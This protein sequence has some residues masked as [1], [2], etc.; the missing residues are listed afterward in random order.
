MTATH[1]NLSQGCLALTLGALVVLKS[2]EAS[3][4]STTGNHLMAQAGLVVELRL[5]VVAVVC[6]VLVCKKVWQTDEE[7]LTHLLVRIL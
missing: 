4:G 6:Q 5:V 7:E 1:V 2:L 3:K